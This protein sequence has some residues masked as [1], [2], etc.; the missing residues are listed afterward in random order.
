[1]GGWRLCFDLNKAG[2]YMIFIAAGTCTVLG[3]DVSG[4]SQTLVLMQAES[5][6][7]SAYV[8]HSRSSSHKLF[9]GYMSLCC[10][11]GSGSHN[12]TVLKFGTRSLA[13]IMF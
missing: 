11:L 5:Q 9:P 7:C 13:V 12:I 10:L 3:L 1:M 4:P 2:L 8:G 6:V